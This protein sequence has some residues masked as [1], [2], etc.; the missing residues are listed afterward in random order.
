MLLASGLAACGGAS[1]P[2]AA[3]PAP[4]A[5]QPTEAEAIYW[6]RVDSA[7]AHYVPADVHFLAGMI[8][9][10]GQAIRMAG[11]VPDRTESQSIRALAGRILISQRDEIALM[12]R[13]LRDRGEEVPEVGPDG[14]PT[15]AHAGHHAHHDGPGMLTEEQL[16]SLEAASGAEFDRLF[17]AS[18]IEHHRGAVEMVRDLLAA[19]GAANDP[20][21]FRIA[22]DV[23]ADQIAEV[24]RM[25]R[26]LSQLP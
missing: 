12:Q 11:M 3:G 10:H 5:R 25:E 18:M 7:R 17:L 13:W 8:L 26:L 4:E 24:A 15:G 19:D 2:P 22:S 9:H 14:R 23:Q 16:L 21:I 6:A 20:E 1:A